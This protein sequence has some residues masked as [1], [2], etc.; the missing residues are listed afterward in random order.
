[1]MIDKL[2]V[3]NIF[4]LFQGDDD[5]EEET[6]RREETNRAVNIIENWMDDEELE[7]T[8]INTPHSLKY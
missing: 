3:L 1:M 8:A 2:Y 7:D 5:E 6:R 4:V